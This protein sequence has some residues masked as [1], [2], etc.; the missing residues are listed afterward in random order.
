M[1]IQISNSLEKLEYCL[2]PIYVPA[3]QHLLGAEWSQCQEV[4][5]CLPAECSPI[6]PSCPTPCLPLSLLTCLAPAG[7][8][9]NHCFSICFVTYS[10]NLL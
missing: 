9:C 6:T 1:N 10:S 3:W 7:F 2:H 4:R 5:P 8:E